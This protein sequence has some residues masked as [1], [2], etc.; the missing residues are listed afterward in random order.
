MPNQLHRQD[1]SRD[2]R[3]AC[4]RHSITST[5]DSE[6]EEC[7]EDTIDFIRRSKQRCS[8]VDGPRPYVSL[9]VVTWNLGCSVS[10]NALNVVNSIRR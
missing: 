7:Y 9:H 4:G 8:S 1:K 3:E 5:F 10:L 6:D 2:P